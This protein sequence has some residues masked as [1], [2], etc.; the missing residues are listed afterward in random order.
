MPKVQEPVI[1][2]Y[3]VNIA[4]FGAIGNGVTKNTEAIAKAIE[5]AVNNGGGKVIFPRGMWL[6]GPIIMKSNINLHLEEGAL[7]LFSPDFD[8]YPL[9]AT[10]FEG[11]KYIS[12]YI[13]HLCKG[14]GEYSFYRNGCFRWQR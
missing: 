3:E 12:L 6:T 2:D 1:P 10:S 9:I 7:V 8:D 5:D 4:D 13:A 11:S 14:C